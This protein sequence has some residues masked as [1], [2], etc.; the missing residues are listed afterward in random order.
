MDESLLYKILFPKRNFFLPVKLR[1]VGFISVFA[2]FNNSLSVSLL[3]IFLLPLFISDRETSRNL[4]KIL[5]P[6]VFPWSFPPLF[7]LLVLYRYRLLGSYLSQMFRLPLETLSSHSTAN[8][9]LRSN[10]Y[11]F[12][13]YH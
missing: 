7:L 13:N 10:I 3:S 12:L 1:S 2:P 9:R 8:L 4:C 11:L 6:S 5:H